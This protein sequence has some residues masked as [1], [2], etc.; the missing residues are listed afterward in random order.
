[1]QKDEMQ[2]ESYSRGRLGT[3]EA[4]LRRTTQLIRT[5]ERISGTNRIFHGE[6]EAIQGETTRGHGRGYG[7]P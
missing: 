4:R 7:R 2:R 3:A 5:A 6:R 1:M